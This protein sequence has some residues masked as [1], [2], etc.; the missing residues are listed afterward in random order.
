MDIENLVFD[1]NIN[2]KQEALE[3]FLKYLQ[4]VDSDNF[5]QMDKDV[6]ELTS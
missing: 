3:E 1:T 4:Y 6:S 2:Q 5:A